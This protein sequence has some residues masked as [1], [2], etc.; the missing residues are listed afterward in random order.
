MARS[1]RIGYPEPWY[2]VTC[3]KNEKR[4]L[5][6][7]TYDKAKFLYILSAS[8]R[9]YS[10]KPHSF[11]IMRNHFHLLLQTPEPNLKNIM[12]C[13]NTTPMVYFDRRQ[14]RSGDLFQG[15]YKAILVEK[16]AHLL[17]PSRYIHLNPVRTKEYSQLE[18]EEKR[19]ILRGNPR[20]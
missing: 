19:K 15:R 1:F 5:L 13:F 14:R 9:L 10:P 4:N 7:D 2:H 11:L 12:Q 16:D 18:V 17:E 3:R 20:V 8:L 6:G